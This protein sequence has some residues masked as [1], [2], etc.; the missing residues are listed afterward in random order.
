LRKEST[1]HRILARQIDAV[2]KLSENFAAKRMNASIKKALKGK[3][4]D[5]IENNQ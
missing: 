3:S 2:G 5:Q 4:L 1:E